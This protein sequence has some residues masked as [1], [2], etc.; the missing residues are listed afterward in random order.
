MSRNLVRRRPGRR[1]LQ[2]VAMVVTLWLGALGAIVSA[3][4][5]DA[6][7]DSA[8]PEVFVLDGESAGREFDGL[9]AVSAGASTR[10]LFDYPEPERSQVLDYLFKPGY[11]AALQ[12]LK[13][14]IGGDMNSTSGSE[15]SHQRQRGQVDC[16]RGYEWWLMKEAKKRNADIRLAGLQWGAPGWFEGGF[17]SQDNIDYLLSWLDC[18][19]S[20]GLQLDYMGG[21]NETDY[22]QAWFVAWKKALEKHHP[23]VRLVAADDIPN[24]GWRVADSMAANP[25][26]NDA[27]DVA[28][29]H[30]AC[31]H[32]SLYQLCQTTK[33]ARELNKPLWISELSSMAHDAGAQPLAR[34]ANRMYIDGRIT[35]LM[36]WSPVSA[37][38]ANLPLAD[39][40]LMVA[41]WPW[42]GYYDVGDS[43]WSYAHTTQ[44]AQPGWRY[45]DVGSARHK[46]GAT[47]VTMTSPN[48]ADWSTVI[49]AID[50]ESPTEATFQI[51]NLPTGPLQLWSTDL[52]SGNKA[53]R[54][55]HVGQVAVRDGRFTLPLEPGHLYTVTTTA[56]QGKGAAA[57]AAGVGEQLGMPFHENFEKVETGR[58]AR[59]FS[60]LSGA[61]E[62]APC[63]AAREGTCYRQQVTEAPISWGSVGKVPLSTV[64]GD[65]RWWGDY[66]VRTK[67]MLEQPG[68]VEVGGRV[69]GQS[70]G[71]AASGYHFQVGTD[72]WRL[73]SRD[74]A[75]GRAATLASGARSIDVGRWYEISLRM[76]GTTIS[77]YVDGERLAQLQ[78]SSQRAGNAALGVSTWDNAQ[79]D[80]V[81][82]V[83]SGASPRFVDQAGISA[84]ATS[85]HGFYRGWT[86]GAEHVV[87]G[88]PETTW[89][90]RFD[91][92]VGLPQAVTL[93]LGE[94]QPVQAVTYQP[95]LDGNGSGM[96]TDYEV[97]LSDDG[98]SFRKVAAGAWAATSSTK[99]AA[100]KEQAAR[101]VRLTA[102]PSSRCAD[103]RA[104]ATAGELNIVSGRGPDL[105][106]TPADTS[107]PLPDDAPAEFRRLVPQAD[108]SMVA[109]STHSPPYLPCRATDGQRST[110]W[111]SAPGVT[112][113]LPATA[114]IDLGQHHRARG[115]AYL[116]RQ[117]GNGNGHITGYKISVSSDGEIFTQL[118]SG[119]W[120]ADARM[121]FASWPA[122]NA[123]YVRLEAVSGTAGVAAAAEILIA[124]DDR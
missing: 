118:T 97:H 12:L 110:F 1:S 57:P 91:Q 37:W 24:F 32:R 36:A 49:E 43:I 62:A 8:E 103:S 51:E 22:N 13:V 50:V 115:L 123:R 54:F 31:G 72:G 108:L 53:D 55:R 42:S 27:V 76:D 26:F 35:G 84:T 95:R 85:A 64:F 18:A 105:T 94:R 79:F 52:A 5:T 4:G 92:P 82:V 69:S 96:I 66:T 80:D 30:S 99:V 78:D 34:A 6:A 47:H 121:K 70:W 122:A 106:S 40:G 3:A 120:P 63:G 28:G 56:G 107:S 100:W 59:F 75:T 93:D 71:T 25:A 60:D 112:R 41:E 73:T 33:V 38:Y 19:Q 111:H 14:E 16:G 86:H 67:A 98:Q 2:I 7:A 44:F 124:H 58:T 68:Y 83:P 46:S 81:A 87:D 15:P 21:W 17:W 11:G 45:L 29:L 119:N 117:D 90:S 48:R 9:G 88:R 20:H 23:G 61:F 116:P 77:V 39:T 113:P 114:T 10:L 104:T 65:P 101:Y 74:H 102:V 89:S 109:S